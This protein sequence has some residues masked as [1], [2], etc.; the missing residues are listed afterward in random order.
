MV[1]LLAD[2]TIMCRRSMRGIL[3]STNMRKKSANSSI[4]E[5]NLFLCPSILVGRGQSSVHGFSEFFIYRF[6]S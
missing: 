4:Y 6:V 3:R 2:I 1:F 5:E